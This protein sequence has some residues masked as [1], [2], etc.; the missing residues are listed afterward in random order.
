M[1]IVG[2]IVPAPSAGIVKSPAP[3]APKPTTPTVTKPVVPTNPVQTAISALSGNK[4]AQGVLKGTSLGNLANSAPISGVSNGMDYKTEDA[5]YGDLLKQFQDAW[6]QQYDPMIN[7]M[8]DYIG[9][10]QSQQQQQQQQAQDAFNQYMSSLTSGRNDSMNLADKNLNT[11]LNNVLGQNYLDALNNEQSLANRGM[12]TS[13]IGDEARNRLA[14]SGNRNLQ[15][16]YDQA[17]NEKNNIQNVFNQNSANATNQYNQN[18][19]DMSS[20]YAGMINDANQQLLQMNPDAMAAKQLSDF[21]ASGGFAAQK[22]AQDAQQAQIDAAKAKQISDYANAMSSQ[23]GFVYD[24]QT[25]QVMKDSKGNPLRTLDGQ[26]ADTAKITAQVNANTSLMKIQDER[27]KQLTSSTGYLYSNGKMVTDKK[28]NPI[29]TLDYLKLDQKSQNDMINNAI[30]QQNA[31]TSAKNANT[32]YSKM[33]GDLA[34]KQKQL[35]ISAKN[36]D[37]KSGQLK[38]AQNKYDD[39][40]NKTLASLNNA[41][42]T[43]Q[44]KELTKQRDDIMKQVSAKGVT[45]SQKKSLM[46]QYSKLTAQISAKLNSATTGK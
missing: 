11:T 18:M 5:R 28:G 21:K 35:E 33:L 36:L 7:G 1:G 22:Q 13:G 26:K 6:H 34:V 23:T 45:D 12:N 9:G 31:N 8:K 4:Q 38:L 39:S 44:V 42:V 15:S 19:A 2:G 16:S 30:K 17:A 37:I 46:T 20:R 40:V 24:P 32:N 25:G 41:D 27:D 3:V 29:K 43:R 10:L 14:M